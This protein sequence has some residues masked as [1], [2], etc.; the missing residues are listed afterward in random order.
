MHNAPRLYHDDHTEWVELDDGTKISFNLRDARRH[1]HRETPL[2]CV[3][4]EGPAPEREMD[5]FEMSIYLLDDVLMIGE[6]PADGTLA[7]RIRFLN[8]TDELNAKLAPAA[9]HGFA[10]FVQAKREAIEHLACLARSRYLAQQ[11]PDRLGADGAEKRS[12]TNA[13]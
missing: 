12:P 13:R 4:Y 6:V 11:A 1:A 7:P 5:Y 8:L 3:F 9:A 2:V 10:R